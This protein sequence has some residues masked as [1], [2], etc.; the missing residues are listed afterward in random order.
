VATSPAI[1]FF[2]LKTNYI[3]ILEDVSGTL[4][5][6]VGNSEKGKSGLLDSEFDAV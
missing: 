3:L 2:A 4:K 1:H 5:S 6:M